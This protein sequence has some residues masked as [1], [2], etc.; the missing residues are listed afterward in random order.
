MCTRFYVEPET[1]EIKAVIEEAKKSPLIRKF[2]HAGNAFRTS[3]EIRPTDVVPVIAPGKDGTKAAFPMRWGFRIPGR[4]V[5]VN[6][7]TETAAEKPVFR[8]AWEK[9]RCVIPASW[10]YE[11]EH[12]KSADGKTK[13]GDKYL[14]QPVGTSVTWL[15]GLYRFEEDIPVFTILTRAPS[16]ELAAIH[17]RMPLIMPDT[18][19]NHWINNAEKPEELLQYALTDMIIEKADDQRLTKAGNEAPYLPWLK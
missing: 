6:A 12:F 5:L 9:H 15:C 10:Y 3:G 14:I 1:E 13:T 17:D 2:L 7:R 16:K 18:Y 19:V 4:P 8:E 11:W